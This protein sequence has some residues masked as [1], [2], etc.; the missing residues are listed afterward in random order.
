M[1]GTSYSPPP[2]LRAAVQARDRTCRFPGC[3]RP[4]EACALD[5][6][7]PYP[8]GQ[9]SDANLACLC[10]RHHRMKTHAKW[11]VRTGP[12]EELVWTSPHGAVYRTHPGTWTE[13]EPPEWTPPPA[14]G[15]EPLLEATGPDL[16]H[17]WWAELLSDWDDEI[18]GRSRSRGGR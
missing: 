1:T 6:L 18:P 4:A 2:L 9:T 5:H 11:R 14:P 12:G 10:R 17:A 8:R 13:P 7:L 3:R 15:A 16:P